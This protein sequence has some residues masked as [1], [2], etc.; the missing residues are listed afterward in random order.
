MVPR[1]ITT[2]TV[3]REG[4]PPAVLLWLVGLRMFKESFANE[5][6]VKLESFLAGLCVVC[7]HLVD[8]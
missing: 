1:K 7:L 3:R 6:L 2:P 8:I 5:E 4:W